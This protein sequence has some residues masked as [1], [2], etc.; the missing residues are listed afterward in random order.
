MSSFTPQEFAQTVWAF[1]TVN[2]AFKVRAACLVMALVWFR[3]ELQWAGTAC[4]S[5]MPTAV[6]WD[7]EQAFR[8]CCF[9]LILHPLEFEA[10]SMQHA[11]AHTRCCSD[12]I[13]VNFAC[14]PHV[15]SLTWGCAMQPMLTEACT[16]APQLAPGM[17]PQGLGNVLWALS[18]LIGYVPPTVLEA[19][20]D[21][22]LDKDVG[23][24]GSV[25]IVL[26]V[27]ALARQ[28]SMR[29][30]LGVAINRAVEGTLPTFSGDN[31]CKYVW[32]EI[33]CAPAQ[34]PCCLTCTMHHSTV[35]V[36]GACRAC[37]SAA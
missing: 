15:L 34:S 27:A 14:V 28:G 5:L 9:R 32:L 35:D 24:F 8:P 3:S 6:C 22:C 2:V 10:S 19:T 13:H 37:P 1:A 30:E 4:L 36:P 31:L 11:A 33:S 17:T 18:T 21:A 25:N 23:R 16:A 29:V 7:L 26:L 20:Q 12:R